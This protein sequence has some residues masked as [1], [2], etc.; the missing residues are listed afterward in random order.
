MWS[1]TN[2]VGPCVTRRSPWRPHVAPQ[3]TSFSS[4]VITLV[5]SLRLIIL[6]FGMRRHCLHLLASHTAA[7]Q[8]EQADNAEAKR[9][10]AN[11]T[12]AVC[13]VA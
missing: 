4:A 8:I 3:L 11:G 13:C 12:N 1:V 10:H 5:G 7:V 2:D 9:H 6:D